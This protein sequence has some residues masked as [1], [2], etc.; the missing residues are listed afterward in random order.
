MQRSEFSGPDAQLLAPHS[1]KNRSALKMP[2]ARARAHPRSAGAGAMRIRSVAWLLLAAVVALAVTLLLAMSG[3]VMAARWHGGMRAG[4]LSAA[5]VEHA[6]QKQELGRWLA[7][8]YVAHVR[9]ELVAEN[10]SWRQ[11]SAT[12]CVRVLR[13]RRGMRVALRTRAAVRPA[14]HQGAAREHHQAGRVGDGR[15]RGRMAAAGAHRQQRGSG[16]A[17]RYHRADAA[18]ARCKRQSAQADA[19]VVSSIHRCAAPRPT[20][21]A[22]RRVSRAA[23]TSQHNLPRFVKAF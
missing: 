13:Q 14:G 6:A 23:S 1:A 5:E 20:P 7:E 9:G 16:S 4:P 17:S 12:R 18:V 21:P 22:G 11:R 8:Q 3:K 10:A 19:K 15:R 2:P